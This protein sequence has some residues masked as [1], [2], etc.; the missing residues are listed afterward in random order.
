MIQLE[1]V[2][3]S[4]VKLRESVYEVLL[5]TPQ[6]QIA[7]FE[8]H[9]PLVSTAST[10][11]ISV[12]RKSDH[13]DDMMEHYAIDTG[14]IEITDNTVRVLVDE[15]D[16]DSEVSAK[17]AEEALERAKHLRAEARDQVSLDKAQSLVD[18]QASRLKIAEL[19]RRSRR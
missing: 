7:V 4:G 1:L 5:P 13:P 11:I 6:G 18:R 2:T 8:N 16:K 19:R 17:E 9:A 12:R 14:V 3:L 10:G 15:A